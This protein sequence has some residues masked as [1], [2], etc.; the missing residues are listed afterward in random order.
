MESNQLEVLES[1][2]NTHEKNILELG[3]EHLALVDFVK[4]LEKRVEKLEEDAQ[5]DEWNKRTIAQEKK[6]MWG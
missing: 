2:L 6:N 1:I 3:V 4:G 5:I